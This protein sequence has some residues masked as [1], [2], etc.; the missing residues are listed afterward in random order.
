MDVGTILSA[1]AETPYIIFLK[2]VLDFQTGPK[3]KQK[4]GG[5]K[6]CLLS[7]LILTIAL[8]SPKLSLAQADATPQPTIRVNSSLV[9]IDAITQ[10]AKTLLPLA[11]LKKE[12]FRVFDNDVEMPVQ[13]FDVG[14]RY[15][16]RPISLWLVV[17][18]NE[19]DWD[20]NGSGFI[21]KKGPLLR[22]ALNHLDKNDTLGVAHWCD[23]QTYKI[24][25]APAKDADAA[26]TKLENL[27]HGW[28]KGVGTRTGELAL[29]GMLR[30]IL[31]NV[32]HTT[33]EPLPVIVF[34]YGDHSGMEREEADDLLRD[35]LQTSGIVYGINDGA[36]PVSPIY[37][38]NQHA[39]PNV[40]H[41]LAA[42]T[43]GQFFSVEPKMFATALD[44]ILVQAHF[45][46]VLGFQPPAF[47]GKVHSLRVELTQAAEQRFPQAKLSFRTS[48]VPINDR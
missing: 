29:Q 32:H 17:I 40:A 46:Y 47:D 26:L 12:D 18:C 24:D 25:S 7:G 14:A 48:Y 23:N 20:E 39:Q 36:V 28:P 4:L 27:F 10:D 15:G 2:H 16:T 44:D 11:G 41:F 19:V 34:L 3:M 43:G 33:P 35:L 1:E 31:E 37:L 6:K 38:D 5:E 9:L 22:P 30:L 21:R 42:K 13:S 45:R 8:L